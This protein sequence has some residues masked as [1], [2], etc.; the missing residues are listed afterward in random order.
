MKTVLIISYYWPPAGGPGVQRPLKFARYLHELGWRVVVLTVRDGIWPARDESLAAEVP[1]GVKVFYSVAPEPE[2]ALRRLRGTTSQGAPVGQLAR[3]PQNLSGKIIHW[4]RLNLFIPDAKLLWRFAAR[5]QAQRLMRLYQPDILFSTSPPP[6]THMIAYDLKQRFPV[7]WVADFRDPWSNIHYYTGQRGETARRLDQR[8]ERRI[9]NK[10]DHIVTVSKAFG[11]LLAASYPEKTDIIPNGYD[12]EDFTSGYKRGP[13][14][15]LLYAGGLNPNRW[16]PAFWTMLR[17]LLE[18]GALPA[19]STR[20]HIIGQIHETLSRQLQELF[21]PFPET[22]NLEN[23][24]P[25]RAVTA[26]MQQAD[27]LLLFLEK[28]AHYRGHIPGKVFEYMAARRPVVGCGAADA[29][30]NALLEKAG[31]GRINPTVDNWRRDILLLYDKWKEAVP[32]TVNEEAIRPY[33]RRKLTERL[34]NLFDTLIR[35]I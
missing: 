13:R 10:A 35:K 33:E 20:I 2:Q 14:F 6:T 7:R 18:E 15:T 4:I 1:A 21:A 25:H 5:R 31:V 27:V 19:A 28:V 12:P 34:S 22:L 32:F 16:Y 17:Q 23:Y 30:A 9:L 11:E 29:E 24:M 3:A 8:L 26:R